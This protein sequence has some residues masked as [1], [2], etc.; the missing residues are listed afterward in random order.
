MTRIA[1]NF[2]K[3]GT[4]LTKDG[5]EPI[6]LVREEDELVKMFAK[7]SE[8]GIQGLTIVSADS[9]EVVVI[10][11]MGDIDPMYYSDVMVA[12]NVD[13]APEVQVASVN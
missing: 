2:E 13:D 3:M 12:L 5:W 8:T 7:A 11:I 1:G 10:N 9:S 6:M 4:K